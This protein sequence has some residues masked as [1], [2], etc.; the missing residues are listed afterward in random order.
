[1]PRNKGII[2]NDLAVMHAIACLGMDSDV[3]GPVDGPWQSEPE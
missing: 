3:P 2:A 1:V